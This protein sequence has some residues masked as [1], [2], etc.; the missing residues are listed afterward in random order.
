MRKLMLP[1]LILISTIIS[2]QNKKP[3]THDVYDGWKSAGEKKISN[4]GRFV[5]Y[6]I[7]PQQ[8][9]GV[10]YIQSLADT[11]KKLMIERGYGAD[12]TFNNDFAIAKIKPF[13]ADTRQARIKKKKPD[14]MPKDSLAIIAL[15]DFAIQKTPLLKS[16]KMPEKSGEWLAYLLDTNTLKN[17]KPVKKDT[18]Q[19][20]AQLS[21]SIIKKSLKGIKGKISKEKVIEAANKT[22][23]EIIKNGG[24]D[25]PITD[26]EDDG[27]PGAKKGGGTDLILANLS[28]GNKK[29]FTLISEYYFDKSGNTLL[30]ETAKNPKDTLSKAYILLH[31]LKENKTDTIMSGLNDGKNFASDEEG[32]QWAFVAERD[33]VEKALQKFYKLWYY[34]NGSDSARNIVNSNTQGVKKGFTVSE[35]GSI[36]FSKDGKKLFFGVAP[37]QPPKDTTFVDFETARLDVWHYNDDYIQPQ[38]LKQ[39]PSESKRSYLAVIIPGQNHIVQLGSEDAENVS[40][41]NEGNADWVLA[42]SN[43]GNRIA[44]NWEGRTKATAY[45]IDTKTGSRKTVQKDLYTFYQASP[46][47]KYVIWY[48]PELKNYFAYNVA[49]GKINNISKN[50]SQP[51]YDIETDVPD[52]P[53]QMGTIGWTKDDKDLLINSFYDIWRTD[54]EGIKMPVNLTKMTSA[55]NLNFSLVNLDSE[56]RFFNA[57]DTLLLTALNRNDKTWSLYSLRLNSDKAP[58]LISNEKKSFSGIIKAKDRPI[59]FLQKS[60][61]GS[62]ELYAGGNFNQLT[63]LTN[64]ADQQKEYNWLTA[65]LVSWK[66]FDSKMSQGILYKPED[67][68]P[69]KKYPVLFYFYEKNSNGLYSYKAPAPSASTINIPYFVSNGYLVFDPDIYYKTGYPGESAYNSVVSAAKMLS[70]RPYV[71]STRMGIQGQSWGGYQVAYLVTRTNIFR[72]AGA[73]APVGNMTSAYGGIRW[74]TGMLREFQYEKQ[75]SRIGATLWEKPELYIKNSPVFSANKITTPLLIMHNDADGAVPWY[76][77]IELYSAMRRLGKKVWMLQY[78]NEDHNLVERRNRKDLSIRLSQFFDYYLKGAKPANWI[79]HGVPAVDKG[80]TWGLEIAE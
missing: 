60:D 64:I 7:N 55:K 70:K 59:Y 65:E 19:T 67:F 56:K 32:R 26:A 47:G 27:K 49:S 18:V 25:Q 28:T 46:G 22:A 6:A 3:L 74:G 17:E 21:D 50:I 20:L 62:S 66:M 8:G 61:I 76:Q 38:Q 29:T 72:A 42:Q 2:A 39:L 30:M 78:N 48:Q 9:D 77:G 13:Y 15:N 4:D 23:K 5:L 1:L 41:V 37:I 14:E 58:T 75:Q 71:D 36:N 79:L 54:P 16:V 11:T 69:N 68:D 40:L 52:L 63:Q 57:D 43:K 44:S 80:R 35:N 73:G 31:Q 45:I 10:L 33:S 34:A 51:L 24:K 53:R 12:F